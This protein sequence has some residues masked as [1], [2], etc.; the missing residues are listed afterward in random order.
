MLKLVIVSFFLV[1]NGCGSESSDDPRF[2]SATSA[3]RGLTLELSSEV[4]GNSV[5]IHDYTLSVLDA[6]G[7]PV[8]GLEIKIKPW[9]PDHDHGSDR[10]PIVEANESNYTVRSVSYT[11]PG[12]WELRTQ[13]NDD[14]EMDTATI[15]VTVR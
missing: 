14:G 11:M 15:E 10:P 12:L 5:G 9:M 8:N 7:N 13:I 3:K 4:T 6:S 2:W 1:V